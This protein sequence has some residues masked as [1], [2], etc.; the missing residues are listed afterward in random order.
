MG[1]HSLVL[2]HGEP[3]QWKPLTTEDSTL[4]DYKYIGFIMIIH[5]CFNPANIFFS[6]LFLFYK[7][8]PQVPVLLTQRGKRWCWSCPVLRR[9]EMKTKRKRA[10]DAVVLLLGKGQRCRKS[11][12]TH[13]EAPAFARCCLA[14]LFLF[15]LCLFTPLSRSC[16]CSEA[17]PHHLFQKCTFTCNIQTVSVSF[18]GE[19][20]NNILYVCV[21]V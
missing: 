3:S 19:K 20:I 12:M 6:F 5:I 14:P 2:Y 13:V 8:S 18:V 7:A 11:V 16:E 4:S 10:G 1:A 9:R 15:F 17:L 21:Q